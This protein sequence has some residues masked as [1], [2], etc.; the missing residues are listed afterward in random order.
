MDKFGRGHML[1]SG[2]TTPLVIKPTQSRLAQKDPIEEELDGTTVLD[3]SS[4]GCK[5]ELRHRSASQPIEPKRSKVRSDTTDGWVIPGCFTRKLC[6][7]EWNEDD[8]AE[9]DSRK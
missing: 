3:N 8:A 4:Y 1:V 7:P 5:S 9:P 6:G 2:R